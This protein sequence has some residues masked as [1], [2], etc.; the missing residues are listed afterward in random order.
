VTA[1]HRAGIAALHIEDQ[2]ASKRCG[3]L[4]SKQLVET[5]GFLARIAAATAARDQLPGD[6]KDKIMII[7]RT[8][9]LAVNGMEDALDRMRRAKEMGADMGFVEGLTSD[10]QATLA[11]RSLSFDGWPLLLNHVT[12][13]KSPVS[14]MR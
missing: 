11:A 4:D 5:N 13:G 14:A 3:H 6:P 7:A 1:Y 2:V 9:A 10:E 12:G 8:D